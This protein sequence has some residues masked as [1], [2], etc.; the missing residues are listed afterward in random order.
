MLIVFE[1]VDCTG[2][3]TLT[4]WLQ[5]KLFDLYPQDKIITT[6]QP[7]TSGQ[8]RSSLEK[9]KLG[10][11]GDPT[12]ELEAFLSDRQDNLQNLIRPALKAQKIVICDRFFYSSLVYQGELHNRN[13][14]DIIKIHKQQGLWQEPDVVIFLNPPLEKLRELLIVKCKQK[15]NFDILAKDNLEKLK[16]SYEKIFQYFRQKQQ[17]IIEIIDHELPAIKKNLWKQLVPLLPL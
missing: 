6:M 16:V 4:K 8:Y 3:T 13:F 1:G 11:N 14:Q 12:R 17:P 2:K 15:N 5:Q 7:T 10:K 9:M